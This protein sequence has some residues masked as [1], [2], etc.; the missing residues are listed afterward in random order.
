MIL[1][2]AFTLRSCIFFSYDVFLVKF[3]IDPKV[4][5]YDGLIGYQGGK[6]VC[7]DTEYIL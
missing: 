5:F 3:S 2:A 1:G 7:S 6:D 4:V